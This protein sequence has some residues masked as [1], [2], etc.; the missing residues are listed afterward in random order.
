M[1]RRTI[2]ALLLG[3]MAIQLYFFF[4]APPPAP[5]ADTDPAVEAAAGPEG[6]GAA[7]V[8]S[9]TPEAPSVPPPSDLP[10]REIPLDWCQAHARLTTDGGHL[11]DLTLADYSGDFH[12]K[13]VWA[14]VWEQVRGPERGPWSPYNLDSGPAQILTAQAQVLGMG[15]GDP[16]SASPRVAV[17]QESAQGAVLTG[18]TTEGIEVTRAIRVNDDCTLDVDLTWRNT[19]ASTY[20]GTLWASMFDQLPPPAGRYASVARPVGMVEGDVVHHTDLTVLD[21]APERL[22]GEI[23]WFGIAD[24]YFGVFFVPTE[25]S[26]GALMFA[27]RATAAGPLY[28]EY[29]LVDTALPPGGVH[30]EKL[31]A[32]AGPLAIDRLKAV[33]PD[34]GEVVDFGWF[35]FFARPLLWLLKQLHGVVGNWG[36]A[37]ILLTFIVKTVFYPL[38]SM[39][40]RSSQSMQA[41]QPKLQELREKFADNQEE[42]NRQTIELFREHGVNPLGG[43]LPMIVQMPVWIALYNVLLYSVELYQ[44]RFL[45]LKDLSSPDPYSV[46]PFV[47]VVLMMVQQSMTP[48]GNM[49]PAQQR[50]MKIMPLIFGIFFFTFPSGLVVYIFVNMVLTIAQ[51]WWIKRRFATAVAQP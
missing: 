38:T 10:L 41:L 23:Q 42:L 1:D 30:T 26:R 18:L 21:E 34:L 28:G 15:S 8:A 50:I 6:S 19:G 46:L 44:T 45:Y 17:T 12:T 37:I 40:F 36:I 24:H 13:P 27:P 4:V 7:P 14:W 49:D 32:Y 29:F 11:R 2:T 48:M 47:V 39:S 5:E 20:N 25:A 22:D 9:A 35:A 16:R 33:D 31:R 3:M 51:Q 43:C